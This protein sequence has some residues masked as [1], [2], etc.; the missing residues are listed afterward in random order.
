MTD[1]KLWFTKK[2]RG[3]GYKPNTREGWVVVFIYIFLMIAVVFYFKDYVNQDE[4]VVDFIIS[5]VLLSLGFRYVVH[6]KSKNKTM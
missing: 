4:K 5:L 2:K 1:N 3:G 6:A